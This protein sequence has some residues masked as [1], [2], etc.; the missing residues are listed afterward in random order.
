MTGT[1][2]ATPLAPASPLAPHTL[3]DAA[4]LALAERLVADADAP[5]PQL[6]EVPALALAWALK[7][8]CFAAWSTAPARAVRCATLLGQLQTQTQ[9]SDGSR[10]VAAVA[11]WVQGIA[12]LSA[13]RIAQACTSLDSAHAA[14]SALGQP[15]HA[16]QTRVSQV[17]A[18]SLLGRHDDAMRCGLDALQQFVALGDE[19]A[20]G[21][22]ELN[23]GTLATRQDRHADAARLFRS[24]AVRGARANHRE[25]SIQADIAL[26]NALTWL[27]DFDEAMR[28]NQRARMRAETHGL[29]VLAA[30]AHGA[31]GRIELHRGRYHA[32]LHALATASRG[33]A[34]AAASPQQCIE[35]EAALADAYSAVNLLPE[36]VALYQQVV[37]RAVDIGA[38]VEQARATLDCAR[39]LLRLGRTGDALQGLAEARALFAAQGNAASLAL[40]DLSLAS[41][42]LKAGRPGDALDSAGRAAQALARS[43]MASWQLEAEVLAASA[44]TALGLPDQ[45]LAGLQRTLG[46]ARALGLGAVELACHQGLGRLAVGQGQ[47]DLARQ[48]LGAALALIDRSRVAL[49]GDAFRA[50]IG[51]HAEEAHDLLVQLALQAGDSPADLLALLEQGRAGA[52]ALGVQ[53]SSAAPADP[54]LDPL[55]LKLQWARDQWRLAVA[56]GGGPLEPLARRV[57]ALEQALLE[58]HRRAQLATPEASPSQAPAFSTAALQAALPDDTALVAFHRLGPRLLAVVA[59]RDGV[60]QVLSDAPTLEDRLAGLR[61]QV[62]SQRSRS[63]GL[64]A[65]AA[66]LLARVQAHLQAIHQQMWAGVAPWVRGCARVVVVPHRSLHY[67]PFAALHDG[68]AWLAQ[69]HEISMAPS[70]TLWLA[71]RAAPLRPPRRAL[72]VGHGGSN[73][74]Q[75]AAELQAVAAALDGHASVI[76]SAF[77]TQDALRAALPGHDVLHLACHGQFRADNPSFSALELADGAL[78]LLDAQRLPVAGMLVALS[79]C[80]TGLS[81]VAPGDELLGL[82]RG[83]L[84]AG[85]PTVLAS[86]WMVDDT[87]TARLMRSFYSRLGAGERPAA[88]LRAAQLE[89]A[90]EGAHPFHWAAFALHGQA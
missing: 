67:L 38:P 64:Q 24:A 26:A 58:A 61:F 76:D 39:S 8:V 41:A 47:T 52:L 87:S 89:Q 34:Q 7:A 35:A 28:I 62:D 75:V 77:A 81:H 60:H 3:S 1:P 5:L 29:A 19:L 86:L 66:Q 11:H 12:D 21:K 84:L 48:H 15:L 80:E 53:D 54:A 40:T 33:F 51:A 55:R 10:E 74:P 78:T 90:Q 18:L 70:A 57:T 25:L 30:L 22:I 42:Q 63:P 45:A 69:Q 37:A 6:P 23:L 50:A 13:G 2:G 79:A 56:E 88:A 68:Q 20:A 43:G 32:A 4:A 27:S 31:I 46:Q 17:M 71:G 59:T 65:H 72:A 49:Q 14:F 83:F 9:A 36:A 82:V 73:L 44:A 85:A 16:A